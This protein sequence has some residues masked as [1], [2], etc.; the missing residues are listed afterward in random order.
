MIQVWIS[1]PQHSFESTPR[2][3]AAL[4]DDEKKVKGFRMLSAS[5]IRPR[6]LEI[7]LEKAY[8]L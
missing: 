8:F 1:C 5:R 4:K 3:E 2:F 6:K 7:H